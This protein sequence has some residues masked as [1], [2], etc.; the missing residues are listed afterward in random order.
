MGSTVGV[1]AAAAAGNPSSPE[2]NGDLNRPRPSNTVSPFEYWSEELGRYT[3]LQGLPYDAMMSAIRALSAAH[4]SKPHLKPN[5]IAETAG[6][7][8]S[9]GRALLG[10]NHLEGVVCATAAEI[11]AASV[12]VQQRNLLRQAGLEKEHSAK[13]ELYEKEAMRSLDSSMPQELR[14]AIVKGTSVLT[15]KAAAFRAAEEAKKKEDAAK[16]K[17]RATEK[18]KAKITMF[19]RLTPLPSL[20][21]SGGSKDRQV[22]RITQVLQGGS[23]GGKATKDSV[24]K[25]ATNYIKLH[26]TINQDKSVNA[27]AVGTIKNEQAQAYAIRVAGVL[28]DLFPEGSSGDDECGDTSDESEE[29]KRKK[30]DSDCKKLTATS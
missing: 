22:A 5:D 13:Y 10:V 16:K 25:S 15:H 19:A 8:A 3:S 27:K 28:A 21:A 14:D 12:V 30:S 29:E 6:V 4:P 2:S 17:K 20:V 24:H 1:A 18:E 11:A 9:V 7:P 26:F 23:P